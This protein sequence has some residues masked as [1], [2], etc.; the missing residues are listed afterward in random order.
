MLIPAR[1]TAHTEQN[2]YIHMGIKRPCC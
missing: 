1:N 2:D